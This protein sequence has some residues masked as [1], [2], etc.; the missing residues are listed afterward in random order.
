MANAQSSTIPV[1]PTVF[2]GLG[3]TGKEILLR[4]RMK[5]F[6]R[7]SVTGYPCISYIWI[8]TDMQNRNV[9][10]KED[11]PLFE[12]VFFSQSE[13]V[14]IQVPDPSDFLNNPPNYP[15][16]MDWMP[17]AILQ[18][19]L[20]IQDGAG[21]VRA[22]GRFGFFWSFRQIQE[23]LNQAITDVINTQ[24]R[25]STH[26]FSDDKGLELELDDSWGACVNFFVATS[27]AGGTGSGTFLDAAFLLR[28]IAFERAFK[29]DITG[30][31]FLSS[32]F[33]NDPYDRR[34]ANCYA[35]LK[36]LEYYNFTPA[37][38][39]RSIAENQS[40]QQYFALRK[41]EDRW[42]NNYPAQGVNG[43]PFNTCYLI[44]GHTH[45][46]A[47]VTPDHKHEVFEMASE[48]LFWEFFRGPFAAQKRTLRPNNR[49]Y[50]DRNYHKK[51]PGD[52][53]P[54]HTQMLSTGYS[55][56]GLSWLSIPT[57]ARIGACSYRL[58]QE[59]LEFWERGGVMT[60]QQA[61]EALRQ[62]NVTQVMRQV[63]AGSLALSATQLIEELARTDQGVRF[64]ELL[65]NGVN[66]QFQE[67]ENDI[68]VSQRIIDFED[69]YLARRRGAII[70][71][72][73]QPRRSVVLAK[74]KEMIR[75][76]VEKILKEEG[77]IPLLGFTYEE[78]DGSQ[79][80]V[81]GYLD[82][83]SD[84]ILP[85][86]RSHAEAIKHQ[87]AQEKADSEVMKEIFVSNTEELDDNFV[88]YRGYS[89]KI[90]LLKCR[91]T[92]T[93]YAKADVGEWV[94]E[95]AIVVLNHLMNFINRE[96]K[97]SLKNFSGGILSPTIGYFS[98]MQ[99]RYSKEE[100]PTLS[101]FLYEDINKYYKLDG[102]PVDVGQEK[103]Q[104]FREKMPVL[105]KVINEETQWTQD[106]LREE[107][108]TYSLTKFQN[109]FRR[110]FAAGTEDEQLSHAVKLFN[111]R[112][113]ASDPVNRA[114]ALKIF[115]SG[116]EP[117]VR[118]NQI[119]GPQMP[120]PRRDAYLGLK[121]VTPPA[122][123]GEAFLQ[124]LRTYDGISTAHAIETE[125]E[126][127]LFYNEL[128]GIPLFYLSTLAQYKMSY[129]TFQSSIGDLPCHIYKRA[130]KLPEISLHDPTDARR[131]FDSWEM[132]IL[133]TILRVIQVEP[134][135][136]NFRYF[137]FKGGAA[138]VETL[139]DEEGAVR[140]IFNNFTSYNWCAQEIQ[141]R[142]N[143]IFRDPNSTKN[144]YGVLQLYRQEIFPVEE[145]FL[146]DQQT[147]KLFSFQSSVIERLI[148]EAEDKPG[149]PRR[150][151]E[152]N[153]SHWDSFITE[154]RASADKLGVERGNGRREARFFL[155]N[156]PAF[157]MRRNSQP[158]DSA[159]RS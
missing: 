122:Q 34:Y 103:E 97:G 13:K 60:R 41:F 151:R 105:W 59:M 84:I 135:K 4:L 106:K 77:F 133:G 43:P 115:L 117:Y 142:K 125:K 144:Y 132:I 38:G 65:Q 157:V 149:L 110:R 131:M 29:P 24:A 61:E 154:A 140:A 23:K 27:L 1:R 73:L 31:L 93:E 95:E 79:R 36:E 156:I 136:E 158:L 64:S 87:F 104:L 35:A 37:S 134:V 129:E 18:S 3:G 145:G 8:D 126:S 10:R 22:K 114:G 116:G 124:E 40:Q 92:E 45:K 2:V 62:K 85:E 6:E 51:Y 39:A 147:V 108:E 44:E 101:I 141:S 56:L 90:L 21:Q 80:K 55:A 42:L 28:Q 19:G 58:A 98:D 14:D 146:P 148:E 11:D 67:G 159:M 99:E 50:L 46:G 17:P 107:V 32:L 54:F 47:S 49:Q 26:Q 15:N 9:D 48:Y 118:P 109:D 127:V 78:G 113:P 82:A 5:F 143:E 137:Y 20:R 96:L 91:E 94:S 153:D 68:A 63:A 66:E 152:K 71:E 76:W 121:G 81:H 30:L 89:R 119:F 111:H 70:Q 53:N 33:T 72:Y 138:E 16:I 25:V 139:G 88:L 74:Y 7:Y 75:G 112:Y 120:Q 100:K 83:L 150:D 155:K 128:T 69:R 57:G 86:I 123:P 12:R 52:D 130:E 102:N